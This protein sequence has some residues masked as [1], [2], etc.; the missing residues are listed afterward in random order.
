MNH[1]Q[2][3]AGQSFR[4]IEVFVL[5]AIVYFIIL[6]PITRVVDN[7]LPPRCPSGPVMKLDW[8]VVTAHAGDLAQGTAPTVLMAVLTMAPAVP[9]GIILAP[10]ALSGSRASSWA[11][12]QLPATRSATCR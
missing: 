11:Q 10:V 3:L 8:S 6:F 4:P 9:G 7:G 12:R 1:S 2:T 5:A